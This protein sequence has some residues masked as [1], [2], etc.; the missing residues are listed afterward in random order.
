MNSPQPLNNPPQSLPAEVNFVNGMVDS[1]F[2]KELREAFLSPAALSSLWNAQFTRS[3]A[4]NRK[5]LIAADIAGAFR[6]VFMRNEVPTLEPESGAANSA[7]KLMKE[8]LLGDAKDWPR[9][10]T[11]FP[12]PPPYRAAAFRRYEIACAVSII[13]QAYNKHGPGVTRED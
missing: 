7:T 4:P 10:L 5:E 9:D 13:M 8:V 11:K 2:L 6:S 12:V 3:A 1:K